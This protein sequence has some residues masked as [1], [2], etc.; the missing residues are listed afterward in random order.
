MTYS[1][2]SPMQGTGSATATDID[3]WFA[4]H[5]VDPALL[6]VG[7]IAQS[8]GLGMNS[9]LVAAQVAH[10]TGY[11]ESADAQ[12]KD[13]PAGIGAINSAPGD[14]LTFSTIDAGIHAQ[15]AHLGSYVLGAA[16][17]WKADDPRYADI[18]AASLGA[19]H[20]LSDL[21]GRWAVPGD[22]YGAAIAQLG[23]DLV[24]FA[25]QRGTLMPSDHL[26]SVA[27]G[28]PVV[29]IPAAPGNYDS[30]RVGHDLA[31]F[32]DIE[33]DA[34][35]AIARFQEP[36]QE[37][38]AQLVL[39]PDNHRVVQMVGIED[40]VAYGCGN[41]AYN[42]KA[43]QVEGPGYSGQPYSAA[44]ID[45][46]VDAGIT[47]A[48]YGQLPPVRLTK[49]QVVAG[50]RGFCGHEDIPNPDIPVDQLDVN[51]PR[52]WGGE[53]NHTDPGPTFPWADVMQR[54]TAGLGAAHVAATTPDP[55]SDKDPVTGYYII[56]TKDAPILAFWEQG[57]GVGTYG[58]PLGGM[59][60]DAQN[61]VYWQI[62]EN[63]KIESWVTG[64]GGHPGP[65]VRL[66]GIGQNYM[67]VIAQLR[68][69][70]AAARPTP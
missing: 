50:L 20:V 62:F 33:G 55:N 15:V 24:T 11:W 26:T 18:P 14:A 42:Q 59:T 64:F 16:N 3:A 27:G 44:A 40:V 66:G 9:D 23:N 61:K 48:Q 60:Y 37:A 6:G 41:Y 32:H 54:I 45:L 38:S 52:H 10:E 21:D 43:D 58:H 12:Q 51:N 25:Q 67:H 53:E 1:G 46:Y 2:T 19:V 68:A 5:G 69:L 63:C 65:Y 36:G 30:N 49:M 13:N 47:L 28:I 70:T 4:A 57:G 35:G 56:N 39:D 29:W 31:L 17:P 34:P 8:G 7:V 22:G